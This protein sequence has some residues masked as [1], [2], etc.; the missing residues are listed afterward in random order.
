MR[1]ER[2]SHSEADTRRIAGALARALAAGD[3]LALRGELGA[4]KTCFVRGLAEALGI[5]PA[6]IS[7]PTFVLLHEHE[8]PGGPALA[9]ID[10]YRLTGPD[11]AE[12]L[13][14]EELLETAICAIE[15]PD[16]LADLLP[17]RRIDIRLDHAEGDRRRIVIEAPGDLAPRLAH[18]AEV[19]S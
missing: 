14:L 19:S 10:A 7:S 4:G 16:R 18:L 12:T 17:A 15:W 8:R 11:D 2:T 6:R 13:A 3:C 1:L 5:D 9:H